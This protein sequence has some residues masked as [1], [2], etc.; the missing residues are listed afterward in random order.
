[1]CQMV[2]KDGG[3][4]LHH[5]RVFATDAFHDHFLSHIRRGSRHNDTA[6]NVEAH[7]ICFVAESIFAWAFPTALGT[8]PNIVVIRFVCY[9]NAAFGFL[10]KLAIAV[11]AP[12]LNNVGIPHC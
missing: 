11:Y 1:M 3:D 7:A 4:V 9:F 5:G 12:A 8:L 10:D 2:L 6:G